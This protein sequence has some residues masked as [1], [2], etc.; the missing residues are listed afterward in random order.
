[1]T[2]RFY[3]QGIIFN[4]KEE[5]MAFNKMFY[6]SILTPESAKRILQNGIE[7]IGVNMWNYSPEPQVTI[8][9]FQEMVEEW[10]LECIS[11]YR[12]SN[13]GKNPRRKRVIEKICEKDHTEQELF[14]M[15]ITDNSL[16]I[17][18]LMICVHNLDSDLLIMSNACQNH[19]PEKRKEKEPKEFY[20]T[21][22]EIRS[23]GLCY[24]DDGRVID[25]QQ[26]IGDEDEMD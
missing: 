15:I 3:S 20:G 24:E 17:D 23:D 22:A 13:M 12:N 26:Y 16:P 2:E 14:T 11:K 8:G 4:S 7:E 21:K 18:V 1:M 9:E 19:R 25:P 10:V 6:K 5:W